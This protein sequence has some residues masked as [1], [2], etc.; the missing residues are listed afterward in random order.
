MM[1]LE[2][3]R[4][5]KWNRGIIYNYRTKSVIFRNK[6]DDENLW[7]ILEDWFVYAGF[8][9]KLFE[10]DNLYY[11]GHT[12]RAITILGMRFS[13]GYGYESKSIDDWVKYAEDEPRD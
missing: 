2:R 4:F 10:Y 3:P 1:N 11:D 6:H 8:Y 7:I 5:Q 9:P 12:V 13:I